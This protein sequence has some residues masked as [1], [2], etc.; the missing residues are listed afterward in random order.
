MDSERNYEEGTKTTI[1]KTFFTTNSIRNDQCD[2]RYD[3]PVTA[4][5]I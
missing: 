5:F 2:W 4:A 3:V 1:S